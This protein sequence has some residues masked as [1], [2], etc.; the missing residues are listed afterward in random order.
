MSGPKLPVSVVVPFQKSRRWFFEGYCL[1]SIEANRPEEVIVV[2][3]DGGANEKRNAGAAKATQPYLLFI[4]DD[5]VIPANFIETLLE[6][7]A[8]NPQAG[9]AYTS[10]MGLTLPGVERPSGSGYHFQSF[11]FSHARLRESSYVST[12]SLMRREIFAPFDPAILRLQDWD[13]FLGLSKR[14]IAG[15]YEPKVMFFSFHID[16]GITAT[17]DYNRAADAVLRKYRTT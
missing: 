12:Q 6:T 15:V 1:P 5:N 11:P 8:S 16:K 13:F 17:I 9:Y 7:L 4:D 14:G 3:Q 10:F 2:D